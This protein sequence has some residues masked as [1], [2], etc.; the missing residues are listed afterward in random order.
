MMNLSL[1][2]LTEQVQ[3]LMVVMI[4]LSGKT[5]SNGNFL[6]IKTPDVSSSA[7][8]VHDIAIHNDNEIYITGYFILNYN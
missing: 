3:H 8:Q 5:D 2:A 7:S 4:S 1:R 6:W